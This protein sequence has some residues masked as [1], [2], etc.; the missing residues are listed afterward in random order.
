MKNK[1]RKDGKL[2]LKRIGRKYINSFKQNND[3]KRIIRK[4]T[5]CNSFKCQ[6]KKTGEQQ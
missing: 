5:F 2:V 1:K 4:I 6:Y 3:Q